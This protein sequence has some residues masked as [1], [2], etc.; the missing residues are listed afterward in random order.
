MRPLC[1]RAGG[2]TCTHPID[3]LSDRVLNNSLNRPNQ[4]PTEGNDATVF[5]GAAAERR[6]AMSRNPILK[7]LSREIDLC[8]VFLRRRRR[9]RPRGQRQQPN[10][11]ELC[12]SSS[13]C[14]TA[15]RLRCVR[16]RD[17]PMLKC[18]KG[19]DNAGS[20]FFRFCLSPHTMCVLDSTT[21][22]IS[23]SN[24]PKTVVSRSLRY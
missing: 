9:Y 20:I 6:T 1:P 5:C 14:L 12:R 8:P 2:G 4:E 17:T 24:C 15:S 10:R 23:C 18:E 7:K 3:K 22:K 16:R 21:Y 13:D 11:T 19:L